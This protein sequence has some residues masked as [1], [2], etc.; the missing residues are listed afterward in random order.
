MVSESWKWGIKL[1]PLLSVY[2]LESVGL[3]LHKNDFKVLVKRHS[4]DIQSFMQFKRPVPRWAMAAL[5]VKAI[6]LEAFHQLYR[7]VQK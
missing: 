3:Y 7:R 2:A 4:L 1:T 6:G 5:H